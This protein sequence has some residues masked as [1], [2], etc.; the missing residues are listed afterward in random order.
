MTGI[1]SAVWHR[2]VV[3]ATHVRRQTTV[4]SGSNRRLRFR[5]WAINSSHPNSTDPL[6]HSPLRLCAARP[7]PTTL[8]T[9]RRQC[10]GASARPAGGAPEGRTNKNALRKRGG[11]SG[12]PDL[13]AVRWE[14]EAGWMRTQWEQ[15]ARRGGW[16]SRENV[17]LFPLYFL[18]C[19]LLFLPSFFGER[20]GA[21]RGLRYGGGPAWLCGWVPQS[22]RSAAG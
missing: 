13:P 2:V 6:D 10:A 18:W 14:G 4:N 7:C 15:M 5:Q 1:W 17:F 9:G 8:P 21:C 3:V 20:G 16:D 12:G 11:Y 19:A 22:G